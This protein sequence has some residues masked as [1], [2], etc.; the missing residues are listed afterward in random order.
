MTSCASLSVRV[1]KY[2]LRVLIVFKLV[3]R[4]L[5]KLKLFSELRFVSINIYL[6]LRASM[7]EREARRFGCSQGW[8]LELIERVKRVLQ[9]Y[10]RGEQGKSYL[11][12]DNSG[13]L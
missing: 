1:S 9:V 3:D 13:A 6:S 4:V 5:I 11:S 7:E 12:Q 2:F 10:V 8:S